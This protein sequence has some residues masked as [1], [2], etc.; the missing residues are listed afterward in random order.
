MKT[1]LII[2]TLV[3]LS[4]F[5][6]R[7]GA[8]W[9]PY[10]QN[11]GPFAPNDWPKVVKLKP[12]EPLDIR[13]SRRYFEKKQYYGF[14]DKP[15]AP[16]LCLAN[17][18]GWQWSW[19]YVEDSQ[20]NV[21]SGPHV[22]YAKAWPKL[23][24]YCKDLNSD[25][26]EDFVIKYLLGGCGTI[27]TFGCNVIFVLSDGDD[28]TVT[29]TTGLWSGLDYFVD[30]KGD[31]RCRFI[32]TRFVNGHGVTGRDGKSHN[33]WVYNLLDFKGGKVVVNNK[34][35]PHFPRWIWYT[36]KPNHQPTTQ[37]TAD[38]KQF[39]WSQYENPIFY[40]P[41]T[42]PIE[43]RI[44]CD[45]NL[46]GDDPL[47]IR[48]DPILSKRDY[49]APAYSSLPDTDPYVTVRGQQKG[50]AYVVTDNNRRLKEYI[51]PKEKFRAVVDVYFGANIVEDYH[52]VFA[53][54]KIVLIYRSNLNAGIFSRCDIYELPWPRPGIEYKDDLLTGDY[55]AKTL[56]RPILLLYQENIEPNID[57]QRN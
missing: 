44:P 57:K 20:G 5:V 3:V 56:F 26:R 10:N 38:Q 55:L 42:R 11:H 52:F 45:A 39:I 13:F 51:V 48:Y 34:L 50:L 15:D 16:R 33:Y 28:Y 35:A 19:L 21:I 12:C 4:S 14:K 31:G 27:Y 24:V 46:F 43:L 25:G 53:D 47:I 7:T 17:R 32:H 40:K 1:R 41:Q 30:I 22:A 23:G 9:E 18:K 49:K 6:C 8:A 37:L 29:P 54:D 2:I 36:F